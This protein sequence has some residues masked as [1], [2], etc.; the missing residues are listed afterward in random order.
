M[1][2]EIEYKDN[3]GLIT[4]RNYYI[5]KLG[6]IKHMAISGQRY[7]SNS[8]KILKAIGMY[9]QYH[10]YLD[11]QSLQNDK[12]SLPP[13]VLYDPTEKG[14]FSNIIGKAIADFLSKKID[15]SI[16]TT[17]YEAAMKINGLAIIGSRPDLL[18][19][20]NNSTFAIEAKGYSRR[21]VSNN[22]MNQYK[23]QSQNGSIPVNF[24]VASVSYNLY[25]KVKCKY[26]DPD[27]SNHKLD[28]ELFTQL[29]KNYYSSFLDFIEFEDC[30][31]IKYNNE[32]FYEVNILSNIFNVE[33]TL[34][35]NKL[36]NYNI[37]LILPI[38]I[39]KYAKAGLEIDIKPFI[40]ENTETLYIDT[41]RIGLKLGENRI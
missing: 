33:S 6:L 30:K 27:Q 10:Y 22:D 17:N 34:F 18:A 9:F 16:H 5:S 14:Q 38:N 4:N 36:F 31:Q 13:D 39:K 26:H 15:N 41:D 2:I 24:T 40:F 32:Y 11:S 21:S 20:A 35:K 7:G 23:Q 25:N 28:T 12:F 29:T 3:N 1:N 8:Y 19:F 37:K